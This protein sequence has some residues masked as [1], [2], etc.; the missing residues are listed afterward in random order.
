[1]TAPRPEIAALVREAFHRLIAD[2]AF[3][4]AGNIAFRIVF[5]VF[6]FLIFLTTLAGFFGN[7]QLAERIVGFLLGVAPAEIVRPLVPEIRSILTVPRTGLLSISAILTIWSAMGG[8]DSVRVGLNRAYDTKEDRTVFRLYGQ[9]IVFVIGSAVLLLVIA[10][11]I[12]LA[13]LLFAFIDAHFP[14]LKPSFVKFDPLRYPIA[15]ILLIGGVLLC[16]LFLPAR[17]GAMSEVVPGVLLTVAVW[18]GLSAAFSYYLVR[19][20][21]FA[22]TYASLSGFFAA[23][24]FVYLAAVVL[25]L[26]GEVN[27]VIALRRHAPGG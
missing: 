23:M 25:I 22:S 19:F 6:P 17:R 8:I 11:L 13:P 10:L 5:S 3:A 27:R 9:G 2:E 21:T 16:H 20:N 4:L 24:F 26:G 12:V 1:M 18:L 14:S 15:I 7:E